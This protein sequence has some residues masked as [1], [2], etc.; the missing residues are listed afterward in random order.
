MVTA[1]CNWENL[2]DTMLTPVTFAQ[3]YSDVTLLNY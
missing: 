3:L 1:F 2:V